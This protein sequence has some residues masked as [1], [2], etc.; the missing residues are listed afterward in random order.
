MS[1]GTYVVPESQLNVDKSIFQY[2]Y[3]TSGEYQSFI[4]TILYNNNLTGKLLMPFLMV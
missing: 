3:I 2:T 4:D 1:I